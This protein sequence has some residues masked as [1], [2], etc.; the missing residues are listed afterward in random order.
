MIQD[1]VRQMHFEF[2]TALRIIFGPGRISEAAPLAASLGKRALVVVGNN[3][4]RASFLIERLKASGVDSATFSV[5]GEPSV[6]TIVKGVKIA[7]SQ[8]QDLIIGMGGGSVIDSGKA[9][10]ALVTNRDDVMQYLEVIGAGKPFENPSA[11]YIAIPTTAGTGSEVTR[12]AVLSSPEHR[13]KVSMR[14]SFMMPRIALVD[15]ETTHSLTPEIT[16][17]TGFDA[18]T[19]LIEPYVCISPNPLVDGIC[20][21]GIRRAAHSLFPAYDN[22]KNADARNDMALAA[23]FGGIALTNA[24]LGAVHGLVGPIGGMFPAPHGA[25]CARLLPFVVEANVRALRARAPESSSLKRF[26]EV[27]QVLTGKA[28]AKAVDS[29][30]WL[31]SMCERMQVK[32]LSSF[33]MTREEI[34]SVVVRA[35]KASS[36]KGNPIPL[37]EDELAWILSQAL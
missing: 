8:E 12:N 24:G 16:A 20:R 15:P 36:M 5:A 33:G 17:C 14:S 3:E 31:H 1:G 26:D 25:A 21:E 29:I 4:Q 11:P 32:P 23:L 35:Q 27:A 19:Q 28:D 37:T 2:A 18:L 30:H 22:G 10:A 9:I 13:V 6:D 34:P 7:R